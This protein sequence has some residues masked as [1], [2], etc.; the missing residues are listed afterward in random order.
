MKVMPKRDQ[1]EMMTVTDA[2]AVGT[3]DD[4][5]ELSKMVTMETDI[6]IERK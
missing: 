1:L 5:K 6:I 3:H 4:D 2:S